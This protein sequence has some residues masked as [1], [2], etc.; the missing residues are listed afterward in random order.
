VLVFGGDE[1]Y[2]SSNGQAT[3]WL[4]SPAADAWREV[5]PMTVGRWGAS[6]VTLADGRVLVTGG[7]SGNNI[8]STR[9]G[10]AE[11]YDPSTER[12]AATA[13]MLRAR[14]GPTLTR[15]DD[16]RVLAVG[17]YDGGDMDSA[18]IWDPETGTWSDAGTIE[19][20]RRLHTA[21]P[22][23]N[24]DVLIVGGYHYSQLADSSIYA[25]N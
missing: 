1:A 13:S 17:G 20:P 16:G 21:A 23:P 15:L 12:W 4:Y 18:E 22:L 5:G 7:T 2:P 9:L 24:G 19:G 8:D 25:C 10:S 6:F 14:T 3:S 11:I